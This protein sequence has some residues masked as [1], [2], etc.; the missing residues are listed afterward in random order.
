MS[1]RPGWAAR[2]RLPEFPWDRLAPYGEQA[3]AHP[4]GI[5]D[6]SIGTPV[7]PTPAVVQEALCAAADAPGY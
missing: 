5:V 3:R 7:D 6:L 1:A 2:A 4:D